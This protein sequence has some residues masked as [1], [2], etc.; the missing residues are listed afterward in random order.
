MK[1]LDI[2]KKRLTFCR[3]VHFLSEAKV[4]DESATFFVDNY[5][6]SWASNT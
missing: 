3:E 2:Q 6:L 1:T 5:I 4:G